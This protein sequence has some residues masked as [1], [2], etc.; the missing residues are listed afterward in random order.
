MPFSG[1]VLSKVQLSKSKLIQFQ[2]DVISSKLHE[3]LDETQKD[4]GEI[5]GA[6][7]SQYFHAPMNQSQSAN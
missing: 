7:A 3:L 4:L 5:S 6:L 1:I 2:G